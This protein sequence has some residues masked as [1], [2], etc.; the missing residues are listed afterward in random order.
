VS[1][2][3]KR[4]GKAT[5]PEMSQEDLL[6][7]I[8][9]MME[10]VLESRHNLSAVYSL[11]G[12]LD[13]NAIP[14]DI[15]QEVVDVL[16]KCGTGQWLAKHLNYQRSKTENEL[17]EE[18]WSRKS[19]EDSG[20]EKISS[21]MDATNPVF[22]QT[23]FE[24]FKNI[25]GRSNPMLTEKEMYQEGFNQMIDLLLP[26][27]KISDENYLNNIV[28]LAKNM[29]PPIEIEIP[30][31]VRMRINREQGEKAEKEEQENIRKREDARHE[32]GSVTLEEKFEKAIAEE[33]YED[34][35]KIKEQMDRLK[36]QLGNFEGSLNVNHKL[37]KQDNIVIFADNLD[38]LQ[39]DLAYD[40]NPTP[41]RHRKRFRNEPG[42]HDEVMLDGK[43]GTLNKDKGIG[44]DQYSDVGVPSSV[45]IAGTKPQR[46]VKQVQPH[47]MPNEKMERDPQEEKATT[48]TWREFNDMQE[49]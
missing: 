19:G 29:N 8:K 36:Q 45:N 16:H 49:R 6:V 48:D 20:M 11:I 28:E 43:G 21:D 7:Y 35:G 10:E 37:V 3:I 5:M 25:W 14:Q 17:F 13:A 46:I 4:I 33:R 34:A 15:K 39:P 30:T 24:N 41:Q 38:L 32:R 12:M 22:L 1:C 27:D 47:N 26:L 9:T 44:T 31:P 23:Y 2:R 40:Q 18:R 42:G